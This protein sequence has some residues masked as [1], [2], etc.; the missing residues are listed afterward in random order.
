MVLG[1]D[2]AYTQLWMCLTVV[3]KKALKALNE[4]GLFEK[5]RPWAPYAGG[6]MIHSLRRG[7]ESLRRFEPVDLCHLEYWRNAPCD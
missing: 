2:P 4:R 6:W 7:S 5:S 1:D 3:Q